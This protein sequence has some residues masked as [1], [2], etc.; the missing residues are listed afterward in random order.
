MLLFTVIGTALAALAMAAGG[1]WTYNEAVKK[2]FDDMQTR[3]DD[4]T[5]IIFRRMDENKKDFYATFVTKEIHDLQLNHFTEKF[6]EAVKT[7]NEKLDQL[8]K[9][10]DA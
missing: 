4:M 5:K 1:L 6:T 7:I 9:K 3:A 8:I 10:G 2:Q